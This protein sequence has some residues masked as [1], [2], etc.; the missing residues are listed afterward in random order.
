MDVEVTEL[1]NGFRVATDRMA[2]R[3][4]ASVGIWVNSGSRHEAAHEHGISHLLEHMAFKGTPTRSANDI[5]EVIEQV[6]GDINA[7]TSLETTSYYT[8]MM[9]D[10]VPLA[11][12]VL[13]DILQNSLFDAEELEREKD[14]ISQEIAAAM[15]MPDDVAF[16]LAGDA[17]YPGQ[18]LGRSVLGTEAHVRSFSDDDL[19][20]FLKRRYAPSR[21]VLS[22]SGLVDHDQLVELASVHFGAMEPSDPHDG[23]EAVYGGGVRDSERKFEQAHL[24]FGFAAPSF[25]DDSSISAALFSNILGGGMSSRLFQRVREDRGLC[26]SIYTYYWGLTDSGLFGLHAATSPELADDLCDIALETGLE[27]AQSGPT[28]RELQ[29]AKAQMRMGLHAGSES[30]AARGEYA[31]RQLLAY[32]RVRSV[33]ERLRELEDTSLDDVRQSGMS[34]IMGSPL[35]FAQVGVAGG[36]ERYDRLTERLSN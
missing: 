6:G 32:G 4:T 28:E 36:H 33:E 9:A 14:V 3:G 34:L 35:S 20:D 25:R 30:V 13:S 27:L 1:Q 24:V 5:A 15:D 31:A 21:M 7:S 10:D 29:R 12:E 17:A 16:D 23:R 19:R 18:S 26:Y 11:V 2:D 8:R 22:A